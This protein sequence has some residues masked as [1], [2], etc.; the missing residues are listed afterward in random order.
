LGSVH[1]TAKK[2]LG[3]QKR[4]KNNKLW[5]IDKIDQLAKEKKTVYLKWLSL[6]SEENKQAILEKK[7]NQENR[8]CRKK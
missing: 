1:G 7:R 4:R 6:K 2:V 5:W 3:S 8:K